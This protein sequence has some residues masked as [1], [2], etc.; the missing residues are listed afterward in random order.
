MKKGLIILGVIVLV[1]ISFGLY[2]KGAYNGMVTIKEEATSQWA[3]VENQY[4][5]RS[6]LIPNLVATV[7]GYASHEQS[8]LTGVI[9]ARAKATQVTIDI[10][11][12]SESNMQKYAEA[13]GS[14]SSALSRLMMVTESYPNLKANENFLALQ[15]Q[16]EGTENRISTERKRFNDSVKTYNKTIKLFPNNIIAGMFNFDKMNYFEA[17]P[18]AQKPVEVKF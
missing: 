1:I 2:V 5:R 4:Q 3:Q 17:S 13:Q 14:L 16:L 7:K 6:D 15:A 8:T 10:D 12:F 18:E 9:E 11:N